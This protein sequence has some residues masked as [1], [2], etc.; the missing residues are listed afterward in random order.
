[1]SMLRR[2]GKLIDGEP[3][4]GSPEL[5]GR[6]LDAYNAAFQTIARDVS[7]LEK[8]REQLNRLAKIRWELP[9]PHP[10]FDTVV[11]PDG[12][13]LGAYGLLL[14]T[15]EKPNSALSSGKGGGMGD[16][17]TV[18]EDKASSLCCEIFGLE[19]SAGLTSRVAALGPSP[20]PAGP[21]Q[22]RHSCW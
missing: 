5:S 21:W 8:A 14:K 19:R 6:E 13:L 3:P 7:E 2:G 15:S 18:L 22:L 12:R 10:P 11:A 1:M 4:G 9:D 16:C 17:S 20:F